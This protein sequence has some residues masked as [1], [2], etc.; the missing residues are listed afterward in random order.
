MPFHSTTYPS[1][2]SSFHHLDGGCKRGRSKSIG[3]APSSREQFTDWSYCRVINRKSLLIARVGLVDII[4][5]VEQS[6]EK[7][8]IGFARAAAVRER[9]GGRRSS[10]CFSSLLERSKT[11]RII[12][13]LLRIALLPHGILCNGPLSMRSWLWP[14]SSGC[15]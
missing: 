14:S 4:G 12:L 2:H 6:Q 1:Y 3:P 5:I 15:L 8:R 10:F 13:F 9:G 11:M 7:V